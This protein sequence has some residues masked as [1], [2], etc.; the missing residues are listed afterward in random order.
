[1]GDEHNQVRSGQSVTA[2]AVMGERV[3]DVAEGQ[4]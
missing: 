4:A 2:E 1:M 3:C